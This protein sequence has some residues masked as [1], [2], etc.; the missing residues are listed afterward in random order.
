[1]TVDDFRCF[2]GSKGAWAVTLSAFALGEIVT[3]DNS[4]VQRMKACRSTG[5]IDYEN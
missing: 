1:M 4:L 5:N 2:L 3:V